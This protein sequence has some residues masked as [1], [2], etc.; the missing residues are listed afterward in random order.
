LPESIDD[1]SGNNDKKSALEKYGKDLVSLCKNHKIDPIIGR[2]EEIRRVIEILSRKTKNNPILIGDPG[3]GKTAIVEGLAYRIY[4]QDISNNLKDMRLIELDMG[5]LI[6]GAKYRGEFE[7]RLKDVLKE[8]E[9]ANGK[10]IMFIDEIHNLVGAGKTDGAMDAANLL[11]P[12]LARGDLR[13]IG[14]TTLN[15]Y[16]MYIEK[17]AALERRFQKVSV[18]E[19]TVEDT[20]SILRGLKDRYESYHGV[21]IL[22]EAIIACAKL[23]DRYITDRFLPD[24]AIDLIDE[25]CASIRIQMDSLP[26]NMDILKREIL[27]NEI[28]IRALKNEEDQKSKERL[29]QLQ[30]ELVKQK[31]EF[32]QLNSQWTIEK[33]K[34]KKIQ[35]LKQQLSEAKLQLNEATNQALYEKAAKLQYET[36]PNLEKEL[37]T[38]NNHENSMLSET[39]DKYLISKVVSK[40]TNIDINRLLSS[41]K[42]KLLKLQDNLSKEVI[43]QDDSLKLVTDAIIRSKADINDYNRPVGSFMFLGPTGVGKTQV[44]K[45]LAQELFDDSRKIIRID[46]SEYM[47]KFNVSKLIGSPSGYVGYED[48][49]QLTNQVKNNPY[50]IVLFDEIEKAHPDVFN[51]LL[52]ILDEGCLTDNKGRHI[53]FKNTIIIMT[54]NLGS[55]YAFEDDNDEMKE[56]YQEA[57]KKF[58]KPELINRIDEIVIFN[59]LS[60]SVIKQIAHK[61][62]Y[63]LG[64]RLANK[65]FELKVNDNIYPVIIQNGYDCEYGARPL[66]R[67]IQKEIETKIA[68]E[69]IRSDVKEG[70]INLSYENSQFIVKIVNV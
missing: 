18:S 53:D 8:V 3:V 64:I 47:E 41:T 5:A 56:K 10:I 55:Q 32:S 45:A 39:V 38:L 57:V 52:Q 48:G 61:F 58:F 62:I 19:P 36:I 54:S 37:N 44:A 11:K 1:I 59:K 31:E 63:E 12:A 17:D 7:E 25:A 46:M 66:K 68:Y 65:N 51:I 28:E 42:D 15:E 4:Q 23:S 21:K 35:D 49:G 16:R 2:S 24:K 43:G 40:W 60:P 29:S 50:S 13:C 67:Y 20:I 14:A 26:S 69:M 22:D 9:E 70:V 27:Q 6:A 33:A 34:I 30:N